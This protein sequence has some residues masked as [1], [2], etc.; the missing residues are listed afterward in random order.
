MW[1]RWIIVFL[2]IIRISLFIYYIAVTGDTHYEHLDTKVYVDLAENLWHKHAFAISSRDIISHT[3]YRDVPL[4]PEVFR[5][6][7]YPLFL[8]VIKLF[9]MKSYLWVIFWQEIIYFFT[10]ILFYKFASE[11]FHKKIAQIGFIFLMLDPGGIAYP[12][13]ILSETLFLPFVFGSL[14]SIGLYFKNSRCQYLLIAGILMAIGALIRPVLVY[15]PIIAGG[16]VL[17][18]YRHHQKVMMHVSVMLLSFAL[19][20]SPWVIRN[21][22]IFNQYFFSGQ[23]GNVIT[24]YH[25]PSVWNAEGI[26]GYFDGREYI[27]K[28]VANVRSEQEKKLGRPL[29]EVEFF[30]LQRKIAIHEL[31]KYPKTY[32]TQ[33]ISGTLKAMYVPFAVEVYNVYHKPGAPIPF[34]ELLP[35]T[36]QAEKTDTLGIPVFSK[37]SIIGK[38]FYFVTHARFLYLTS[39]ITSMLTMV[40]ALLGVFY[41][42]QK[43]DPF[44]WLIM[45]ANFYFT[46]VAGPT[47]YAR[48][49]FP[50]D[51]FWFIQAIWGGILCW[52]ICQHFVALLKQRNQE[53]NVN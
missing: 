50:I 11:L 14:F 27:R 43:K 40:F 30:N 46:S 25:L 1:F 19:V 31:L 4:G 6:P 22:R 32:M 26:R 21:Y 20:L 48:F 7:G 9:G 35:D 2:I 51:V 5:T 24:H 33:W 8:A 53:I 39:I 47:G 38:L 18:F 17:F 44:L 34:I 15:F 12:K 16:V 42:V 29:N 41:V 45:L 37:T 3:Q 36:L 28:K 23:S 49:R 13:L 10:A 52:N